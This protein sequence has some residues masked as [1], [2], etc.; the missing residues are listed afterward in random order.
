M[1]KKFLVNIDLGGNQL[2]SARAQNGTA[3]PT[4]YGKGQFWFDSTNNIF[5]VYNGTLFQPMATQSYVTGLGYLTSSGSIAYST[6]SGNAATTSQTN[7]STLTLSGSN[8]ATQTY[9]GSQGYITS[10][11]SVAYAT[12]AGSSTYAT[13]AGNSTTTSQTNFSA[14]TI[15]SNAVATQAYVTG[16]GYITSSGSSA[17]STNAG[18]A[19]YSTSAGNAITTSQTTF[20]TLST[21]S[22]AVTSSVNSFSTSTGALVVS[23]GVGIAKNVY[24]GGNLDVSG[25]V[26]IS[27]SAFTVSASN[28]TLSD[29]M[30]YLADLN[31]SNLVDI[32]IVGNF[33]NGVYQH[34]GFVRD[35]TDATWK[36]FSSVTTEP[37]TTIDFSNAIYDQLAVG[38]LIVRGNSTIGASITTAGNI[39]AN[40]G[41]F[42]GLSISG[43]P[44]ATQAYVLANAG[45]GGNATKQTYT[46]SGGSSSTSFVVNHT[47][48]TRDINA[49]VYQ[50]S[51]G[52]DTQYAD[53]EVDITR[54]TASAITI[55]FATAPSTGT[56]YNVVIVG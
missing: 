5:N 44:V 52:P 32:G 27:G 21:G 31:P 11:G 18:S 47:L 45:G 28:I 24:I 41:S 38:G 17:Y 40:T 42:T 43:S 33:N 12:N 29:P 16:L 25:S 8:V 3:S 37:T 2:L 7:F 4:S 26:Y 49:R 46:I 56:T 36:L 6:N 10:S 35:A 13:T 55:A 22:I 19:T 15:S 20:T 48:N 39:F 1:A 51:A 30:I 9:V 53:V 14:L 54:T 23:G 50:T 34:T